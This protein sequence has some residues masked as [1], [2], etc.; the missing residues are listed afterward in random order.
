MLGRPE[1]LFNPG[2]T[3]SQQNIGHLS[4][5]KDSTGY[6]LVE[7]VDGHGS[8]HAWSPRM[9][10]KELDQYL[11]GIFKGIRLCSIAHDIDDWK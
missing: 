1:T 6:K 5:D 2:A 10:A 4:L 8:E 3:V 7:V 9:P 11:D